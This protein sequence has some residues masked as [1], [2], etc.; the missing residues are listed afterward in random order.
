MLALETAGV[1]KPKIVTEVPRGT[2]DLEI[3]QEIVLAEV[4]EV[5]AKLLLLESLIEG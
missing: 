1:R 2:L 5:M 3:E 4:P